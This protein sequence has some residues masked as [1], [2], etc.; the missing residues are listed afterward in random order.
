MSFKVKE[1]DFD[2]AIVPDAAYF[3]DASHQVLKNRMFQGLDHSAATSLGSY[4]HFRSPVALSRKS[5]LER[6]ELVSAGKFFDPISED[7]PKG[8]WALQSSPDRKMVTL[9]SLLWPGYFFSQSIDRPR[10]GGAYFGSGKKN[11]SIL[12]MV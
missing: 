2:T 4:F 9:R 3:V 11:S 6:R 8:S 5:V 1:I 12:F 10:F 7:T